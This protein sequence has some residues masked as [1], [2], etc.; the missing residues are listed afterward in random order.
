MES[1]SWPLGI[2]EQERVNVSHIGPGISFQESSE[3]EHELLVLP[4]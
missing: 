1:V 2:N 4:S 3:P